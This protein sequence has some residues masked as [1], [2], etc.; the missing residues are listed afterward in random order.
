MNIQQLLKE[1][2]DEEG[3][4]SHAYRDHL[5]FW[6]IGIGT[7]IDER[8]GGGITKEEALY[9]ARNRIADR[10]SELDRRIPWWRELSEARQ[11]VLIQM[12]FQLGT[13]G[14]LKFRNML[15]ALKAGEWSKAREEAMRSD[16]ARYDTPSRAWKLASILEKG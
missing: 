11:R 3:F 9:L 6:T 7:L 13:E 5:G 12:A 14:L 10:I 2:E 15:A 16:W 4:K 8:K 1:L